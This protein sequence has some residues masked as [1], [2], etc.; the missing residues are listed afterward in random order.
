MVLEEA[1]VHRCFYPIFSLN[2]QKI[3]RKTL[4]TV[5]FSKKKTVSCV[6]A[7]KNFITFSRKALFGTP[8]GN[9]FCSRRW[10]FF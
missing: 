6:G 8:W 4:V 3:L 5:S 9:W 1:D 7:L 2:F 10:C